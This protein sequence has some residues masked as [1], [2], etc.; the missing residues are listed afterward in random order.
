MIVHLSKMQSNVECKDRGAT[1][2]MQER[3]PSQIRVYAYVRRQILSE[4]QS[5]LFTII[6][7]IGKSQ[8]HKRYGL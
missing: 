6:G 4:L 2:S 8:M 5:F 7:L 1:S 3:L